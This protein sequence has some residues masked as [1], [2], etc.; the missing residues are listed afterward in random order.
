MLNLK[1]NLAESFYVLDTILYLKHLHGAS[2]REVLG[3][4]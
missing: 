4:S 1:K 3:K 2:T